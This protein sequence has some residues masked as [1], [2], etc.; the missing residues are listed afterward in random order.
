MTEI[1]TIEREGKH[2]NYRKVERKAYIGDVIL[3]TTAENTDDRYGNGDVLTVNRRYF[4][5]DGVVDTT[6]GIELYDREYV[7]LEP[8]ENNVDHP[9]HYTQGGTEVI[10]IIAQITAGYD[11]G[12]DAYCV[13][14]ALKYLARAPHKHASIDEDIAKAAKYLEFVMKRRQTKEG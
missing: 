8:F 14:N 13:G 7:V 1:I 5:N 3:V 10:D 6:E 9:S 4:D 11:D 12:F 2:V